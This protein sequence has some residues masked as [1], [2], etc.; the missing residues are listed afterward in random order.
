MREYFSDAER[1]VYFADHGT[2]C[3]TGEHILM[4]VPVWTTFESEFEDGELIP[5]NRV[6]PGLLG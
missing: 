1:I 3:V 5:L 6:I 2:S 4:N